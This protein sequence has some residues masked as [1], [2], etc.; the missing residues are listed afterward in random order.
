MTHNSAPML[1]L[2]L[3]WPIL[4]A[5]VCSLHLFFVA[6]IPARILFTRPPRFPEPSPGSARLSTC[7]MWTQR[8]DFEPLLKGEAQTWPLWTTQ[9]TL[10]WAPGA[11]PLPGVTRVPKGRWHGSRF[12]G[13][14]VRVWEPGIPK[15]GRIFSEMYELGVVLQ[16]ICS[17]NSFN[18]KLP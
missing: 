5:P 16:T 12:Q 18:N 17:R 14:T 6:A 15:H 10:T 11:E 2:L 3:R 1:R 13:P 9:L 7:C 8:S 4:P